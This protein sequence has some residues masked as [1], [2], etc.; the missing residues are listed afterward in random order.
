MQATVIYT[1]VQQ[2]DHSSS[3]TYMFAVQLSVECRYCGTLPWHYRILFTASRYY[4][5]IFTAPTVL[6][7]NFPNRRGEYVDTVELPLS[8]LPCHP[9]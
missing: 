9:L 6:P 4:R 3:A 5:I 2:S 1:S 7:W 8:P